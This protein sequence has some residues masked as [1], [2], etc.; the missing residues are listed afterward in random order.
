MHLITNHGL[1]VL[2][3]SGLKKILDG[4]FQDLEDYYLKGHIYDD[5]IEEYAQEHKIPDLLERID[6]N[7]NK[8]ESFIVNSEIVLDL[9]K[10]KLPE[11]LESDVKQA[12]S[13]YYIY[14]N[15]FYNMLARHFF[16]RDEKSVNIIESDM[17]GD[18]CITQYNLSHSDPQLDLFNYKHLIKK[19]E[20]KFV[21]AYY[22]EFIPTLIHFI[23][24]CCQIGKPVP[25]KENW[26]EIFFNE[27][28]TAEKPG[29]V[30]KNNIKEL[31]S[32]KNKEEYSRIFVLPFVDNPLKYV[33]SEKRFYP[34]YPI[35]SSGGKFFYIVFSGNDLVYLYI[36]EKGIQVEPYT[37][38]KWGNPSVRFNYEQIGNAIEGIIKVIQKGGSRSFPEDC[39]LVFKHFPYERFNEIL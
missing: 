20:P 29:E 24:F 2:E 22:D 1:E 27:N 17:Q 5:E 31:S 21:N 28:F 35:K 15:K 7:F 12:I 16:W 4:S 32:A 36:A 13:A 23:T 34:I 25:F 39:G 14:H 3:K 9:L 26:E 30:A 38:E 18:M 33:N 11:D 19:V 6:D 37:E 8:N 10:D